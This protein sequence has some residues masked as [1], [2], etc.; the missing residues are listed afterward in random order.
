[1]ALAKELQSE[2]GREERV[3]ENE[4]E[5]SEQIR[6]Q[7][8]N[9]N[10]KNSTHSRENSARREH[11]YSIDSYE[12]AMYSPTASESSSS[13]IRSLSSPASIQG[14]L[15]ATTLLGE[16]DTVD[17]TLHGSLCSI[18]ENK[19]MQ[20]KSF[21]DSSLDTNE[22]HFLAAAKI[23]G[24]KE[25]TEEKR[26][27]RKKRIVR[28][29][30]QIEQLRLDSVARRK[31]R[32]QEK[33]E[34]TD[35]NA[36][37]DDG[38]SAEFESK[39]AMAE[40]DGVVSSN[41][42]ADFDTNNDATATIPAESTT[43]KSKKKKK[44]KRKDRIQKAE[45]ETNDA[46]TDSAGGI[47]WQN[48]ND[49]S[50]DF[51]S[52]SLPAS[53][54]KKKYRKFTSAA[55][56]ASDSL[57]SIDDD[58]SSIDVMDSGHGS[59]GG[60]NELIAVAATKQED[61]IA[62]AESVANLSVTEADP[63]KSLNDN[64]T[65]N[66]D[67]NDSRHGG[68]S[69]MIADLDGDAAAERQESNAQ[70]ECDVT[71]VVT[72]AVSVASTNN[73]GK[74]EEDNTILR[75][76]TVAEMAGDA[77][78]KRID[79]V[80]EQQEQKV[81]KIFPTVMNE[82]QRKQDKT[83]HRNAF[84]PV[85]SEAAT[86]AR[87][88]R[89]EEKVVEAQGGTKQHLNDGQSTWTGPKMRTDD[90]RSNAVRAIQEAAA[91]GRMKRLAPETVTSNNE[92]E[93]DHVAEDYFDVEN[94]VDEHGERILR[95]NFL[96]DQHVKIT[97][98]EKKERM[99][100]DSDAMGDRDDKTAAYKDFDDV[101]LPTDTLP[102]F[103]RILGERSKMKQVSS[104]ADLAMIA[105]QMFEGNLTYNHKE[106]ENCDSPKMT[107]NRLRVLESI[108]CV[109]A[110]S[111]LKR[112]D[113]LQ[114]SQ[115]QLKVTRNCMCPY[116]KDPTPYQTHKYRR[117]MYPE[118]FNAITDQEAGGDPDNIT[119]NAYAISPGGRKK[120]VIRIV[121]RK[122][123]RPK[124]LQ[125]SSV[126]IMS[127][128]DK[129]LVID[130][131]S[132]TPKELDSLTEQ[133]QKQGAKGMTTDE[134]VLIANALRGRSSATTNTTPPKKTKESLHINN[135]VFS[136][137]RGQQATIVDLST[138]KLLQTAADFI[139]PPFTTEEMMPH[140][141][142]YFFSSHNDEEQK[143]TDMTTE[144]LLHAS[145]DLAPNRSQDEFV[146]TTTKRLPPGRPPCH[147]REKGPATQTSSQAQIRDKIKSPSPQKPKKKVKAA[148]PMSPI[149]SLSPSGQKKK[150]NR[151]RRSNETILA[152]SPI[153]LSTLPAPPSGAHP[154]PPSGAYNAPRK[155]K[156]TVR[157]RLKRLA[158]SASP[159][160][161]YKSRSVSEY[162]SQG[163]KDKTPKLARLNS[164]SDHGS[165]GDKVKTPKSA[166]RNSI[167]DHGSRCDKVKT[168]KSVRRNVRRPL[169]ISDL[170]SRGDKEKTPKSARRNSISDLGSR[171]DKEKT[172]KSVRRNVRRPLSISDLGSRGDKEKIP[173]SVRCNVIRSHSPAHHISDHSSQD[174]KDTTP[175]SA[176]RRGKRSL[177]VS[178]RG[179]R[180]G[181]NAMDKPARRIQDLEPSKRTAS[182]CPPLLVSEDV[183][184]NCSRSV[185]KRDRRV[186]RVEE[187][188]EASL[189]R[190][191]KRNVTKPHTSTS[192][193]HSKQQ[194]RMPHAVRTR[195]QQQLWKP[196]RKAPIRTHSLPI[197]HKQTTSKDSRKT[198]KD[199][200][201]KSFTRIPTS[202]NQ[203][204]RVAPS[205]TQS[206][207]DQLRRPNSSVGTLSLKQ[208][209][210]TTDKGQQKDSKKYSDTPLSSPL[211]KSF[212]SPLTQK[213][214]L[215]S[216]LR[217]KQNYPTAR[218]PPIP[219]V[220]SVTSPAIINEYKDST[221]NLTGHTI[222]LTPDCS[223]SSDL[224]QP[225]SL[226]RPKVKKSKP[227]RGAKKAAVARP[228]Q[229]YRG[230]NDKE[231]RPD[232][233]N[234]SLQV[235]L[236]KRGRSLDRLAIKKLG[237]RG[238][239]NK[240]DT[241]QDK[242]KKSSKARNWLRKARSKS[243]GRQIKDFLGC[244]DMT[245][246]TIT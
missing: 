85:V 189:P 230:S 89:L 233:T 14:G 49:D 52:L 88:V 15:L 226:D 132:L 202:G 158:R 93:N 199:P 84:L 151:R 106:D 229:Q 228:E 133:L 235:G 62:Q 20:S 105:M 26:K 61:L 209:P 123:K 112:T 71:P 162:D 27:R 232:P 104:G 177:S 13:S 136:S 231:S 46:I 40:K 166:R 32:K 224:T 115:A 72:A 1:M 119:Q 160:P 11:R 56:V 187:S 150:K 200:K 69:E 99:W 8:Q 51:G 222:L 148:S 153:D 82:Q 24:G 117:L 73:N 219:A 50:Q 36:V 125:P 128:V 96:L 203:R 211:K 194:S 170:G 70:A 75:E 205:R 87:L 220:I 185:Q 43:K 191:R 29:M 97:A 4:C 131:S 204:S 213:R 141:S 130:G 223:E 57:H 44:G 188:A 165:R 65:N 111:A 214:S 101:K 184:Q 98:Q 7:I 66:E 176:R 42:S 212:Q 38:L 217:K 186:C 237:R 118:K 103:D 67:K 31:D 30:E 58:E 34:G 236:P 110:N 146:D 156:K 41:A 2:G 245:P 39:K 175:Q 79:L 192:I 164:I 6:I 45:A 145:I 109:V 193:D 244:L 242:K 183:S 63:V 92:N 195:K 196:L 25:T 207:Q 59:T 19:Q 35:Q 113:R 22:D 198:A 169:S 168:P 142:K 126:S 179:P 171:G 76:M 197:G 178:G 78:S 9:E 129:N 241:I 55:P 154:A 152:P 208:M 172:P 221:S 37:S 23:I 121:R 48:L 143:G 64:D 173:K 218:I 5:N 68:S 227:K 107:N 180:G 16:A 74:E 100:A 135:Q 127:S 243:R 144:H 108:S 94:Q 95:T 10:T 190:S 147:T 12:L 53:P 83:N 174:D 181:S 54:S 239:D 17:D 47:W 167:S 81:Y 122:K 215:S 86:Y 124:N 216:R 206:L 102:T 18:K 134:L 33:F 60:T 149:N 157:S 238:E 210:P 120:K 155:R 240:K 138:E 139:A 80:N 77:A 90:R 225:K 163:D 182:P 21:E 140:E 246:S 159:P 161:G 234:S 116:C 114:R 91:M 201:G 3:F 137:P 28:E